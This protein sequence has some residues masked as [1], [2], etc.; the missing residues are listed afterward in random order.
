MAQ[1]VHLFGRFTVQQDGLPI[2]IAA[3]N[4]RSLFACLLLSPHLVRSREQ[5][6]AQ[7]WPDAPSE[8]SFRWLSQAL[9]QLRTVLGHGRVQATHT[10]ISLHPHDLHV[11]LWQFD[12]LACSD[13]P[14]DW[15]TAVT[16][17][18]GDLLPDIYDDWIRLPRLQRQEQYLALLEKL[19]DHYQTRADLPRALAYARQLIQAEPLR[20]DVHQLVLRLLGRA[21]RAAEATA[22]YE[23]LRYLLHAELGVEPMPQTTA[24]LHG[25]QRET[26]VAT[27]T[28]TPVT[29]LFVGRTAEREQLV[30]Y[31]EQ[32]LAGQGCLIALEGTAGIGKSRLLQETAVSAHWRGLLVLSGTAVFPP[33]TTVINSTDCK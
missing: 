28:T 26:A 33:A 30:S 9:Y 27:P 21:G 2:N 19:A 6:S 22:H 15:A 18:T 10:H 4:A 16:L 20:E 31:L 12:Q 5:L 24:I 14:T 17:Y 3:G 29:T 13:K 1:Q 23:Q 7:L 11:D 8:K 32:T 25:I